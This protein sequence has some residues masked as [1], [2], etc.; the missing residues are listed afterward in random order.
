MKR[1]LPLVFLIGCSTTPA[2]IDVVAKIVVEPEDCT[3]TGCG[4]NTGFAIDRYFGELNIGG[5][6]NPQ[7]VKFVGFNNLPMG[8]TKLVVDK[9]NRLKAV[10]PFTSVTGDG[11][12]FSELLIKFNG[13]QYPIRI[14]EVHEKVKYW[15]KRNYGSVEAY[16]FQYMPPGSNWVDLC[17][18]NAKVG[19]LHQFDAVVFNAERYDADT[20]DVFDSPI[21]DG[22]FNIACLS[23]GAGKTFMM[24]HAY[25][26]SDPG[27]N[28]T[29]SLDDRRTLV[30]AWT[31]NYCGD[32]Q[33]FTQTGTDIRLRDHLGWIATESKYTWTAENE[34]S[35]YE[36]IWGPDGA[37]CLNR[38]R[39]FANDDKKTAEWIEGIQ[40]HCL[41]V[42][43]ATIPRCTA[44]DKTYPKEWILTGG[45]IL[46]ANP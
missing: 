30:N 44:T 8:T 33:S 9:L 5:V 29:T 23:G 39:R 27:N 22:W 10:G 17:V 37:L 35:T 18:P 7:G 45:H 40:A 31:A 41:E 19:M 25:G 24:R 13:V 28:I 20:K 4:T 36:A 34:V 43:N 42:K 11:I 2:D 6:V 15:A 21:V 16:R 3:L 12:K 38:P 32:G 14:A 46:T 26:S 1:F